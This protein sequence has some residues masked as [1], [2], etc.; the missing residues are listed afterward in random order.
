MSIFKRALL[1]V[2]VASAFLIGYMSTANA[3]PVYGRSEFR[4]YFKNVYDNWGDD[5]WNGGIPTS[6][7]NA[8]EFITYVKNKLDDGPNTQNGV[9]AA[10]IIQTMIGSS[11]TLPPSAAQVAEWEQ[12]VR[13]A[14][15]RGWVDWNRT[16]SYRLTSYFQGPCSG[17]NCSTAGVDPMDDAFL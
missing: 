3:W 10:F 16:V 15:Q 5:V 9:G 17:A 14:D 12:R 4:G 6:V 7:N 11:R 13:Y 1:V 2:G 8:N